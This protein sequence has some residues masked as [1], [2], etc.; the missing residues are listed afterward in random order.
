MFAP[1]L[2]LRMTPVSSGATVETRL[3]C[4]AP[5]VLALY[6]C[7]NTTGPAR[8]PAGIVDLFNRSTGAA[9]AVHSLAGAQVH[10]FA[11]DIRALR[12]RRSDVSAPADERLQPLEAG[13]AGSPG[14]GGRGRHRSSASRAGDCRAARSLHELPAT[15]AAVELA[16]M[17]AIAWESKAPRHIAMAEA[18]ELTS[19][20]IREAAIERGETRRGVGD[21]VVEGS[22]AMPVETPVVPSPAKFCEDADA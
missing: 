1:L 21:M 4:A 18:A 20:G 6:F 11:Q 10:A 15:S 19:A 12:L 14:A 2:P 3:G 13:R 5:R 22:S 17:E 9:D 16:S 7:R 8:N